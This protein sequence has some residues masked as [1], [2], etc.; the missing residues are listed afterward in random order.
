M[1]VPVIIG[2]TG[3]RFGM[4]ARQAQDFARSMKR[5]ALDHGIE[6]FHHGDCLG[7]DAQAHDW[8]L[9]NLPKCAV[10]IHPSSMGNLRA[11]RRGT[12]IYMPAP[13]L[14]R[15]HRIVDQCTFLVAVPH[16]KDE[17]VRS[18]TW[19]TVRYARKVNRPMR[20]LLP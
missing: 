12:Y 14:V 13:P 10:Y 9:R 15:N 3:T 5:L 6:A 18:G 19:A 7:A 1:V 11:Y 2:F 17:E 4:S 16:T 8:V 20:V